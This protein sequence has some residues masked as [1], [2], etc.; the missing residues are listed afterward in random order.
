[1]S[2][3][4]VTGSCSLAFLK[5]KTDEDVA[6]GDSKSNGDRK[7]IVIDTR[8]GCGMDSSCEYV[9]ML[10]NLDRC[11][12][13]EGKYNYEILDNANSLAGDDSYDNDSESFEF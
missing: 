11:E 2:C 1:M 4:E 9:N 6:A 13:V 8:Y 12:M 5:E 10:C 7:M 3:R